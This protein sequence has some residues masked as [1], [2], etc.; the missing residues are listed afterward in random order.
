MRWTPR[1]VNWIR[2]KRERVFWIAGAIVVIGVALH[3]PDYVSARHMHFMMAGMPMGPEMSV[4]MALILIGLV[5][6][7]WALLPSRAARQRASWQVAQAQVRFSALD[8]VK[9]SRAHCSLILALTVGLVVDTMKPA[10]LGFV[11][12]PMAAEYGISTKTA[13]FLAF[14]AVVGTVVGSLTWGRLAD[15]YGRRATL[16]F[17][18]LMYVATCICGFMPSFGWNLVMCFLMGAAAGGMLPIVYSLASESLPARHRGWIIVLM[19]GLGATL[20]YLV[21]S[22]AATVIEPVLSWRALWL[23]NFPTG[24]LL[25]ALSRWIPESPR[26]LTVAGRNEEARQVMATYGIAEIQLDAPDPPSI[27]PPPTGSLYGQGALAPRGSV[28]FVTLLRGVYR[29]RTLVVVLYGVAWGIVNW[30]FIT[31]L[32]IY[33]T[34]AGAG[35]KTNSLLFTSSLLAPP[36]IV[37]AAMLYVRWGSKPSMLLFTGATGLILV[38][39]AAT[40]PTRPGDAA[41]FVPLT[42]ALLA[43]SNGMLAMLSPYAAEIYPT[44]VRASGS[45]IAAAASKLGGTCGPLLLAAAPGVSALTLFAFVPVVVAFGVLW[46]YG[47]E[48]A[49]KALADVMIPGDE[50]APSEGLT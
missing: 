21:A 23:L 10:S 20:G 13:S 16:L 48:T 3:V 46:R 43:S 25:L 8:D 2:G 4:G 15:V 6:G 17:S 42:A 19:S 27:V 37:I 24:L 22:G 30:G 39:F 34:R 9:L 40:N 11:I 26:F 32:P 1:T 29:R 50:F 44:T 45:G 35:T 7:L 18:G 49:R 41:L 5:I 12:P 38:V 47:P 33:L 14:F 28:K 31:F 36:V